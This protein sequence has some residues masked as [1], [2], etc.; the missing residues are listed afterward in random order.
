MKQPSTEIIKEAIS[1]VKTSFTKD[2]FE[3]SAIGNNWFII[4]ILNERGGFLVLIDY[5]F[6]SNNGKL[7]SSKKIEVTPINN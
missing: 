6:N 5:K 3:C 7:I 1:K 4:S 2:V